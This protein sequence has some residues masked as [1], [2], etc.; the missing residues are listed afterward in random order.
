MCA[1]VKLLSCRRATDYRKLQTSTVRNEF[2]HE[3]ITNNGGIKRVVCFELLSFID[4]AYFAI[5]NPLYV[6]TNNTKKS[7]L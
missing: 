3:K 1:I 5:Y 2:Q 7:L 4:I 6:R